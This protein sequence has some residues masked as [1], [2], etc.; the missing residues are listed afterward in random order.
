MIPSMKKSLIAVL[1]FAVAQLPAQAPVPN[2]VVTAGTVTATA[3]TSVDVPI[4]IRDTSGTPLGIDQPSGSRIQSYSL[5]VNYSP[6]ASVS[7][8]TLSR[9]GITQPLTP[10]FESSPSGPGTITLL[11][12]F[13][14]A[15]NLIPFTSNSPLPGNQVAA[16]HITVSSAAAGGS[17]ITLTFD[18]VL[19]QLTDQAGNPATRETTAAVNL[20][21]VNGAVNVLAAPVTTVPATSPT[22]LAVLAGSLG[23]GGLWL[24]GRT[25]S[26]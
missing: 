13:Q 14:E 26:A 9:A 6:A 11:D 17:T 22:A 15:T 2:D 10:S 23:I 5:K 25:R 1:L 20:S 19:T 12:T 8:I 3:G 4:Y 18:P 21:L 16:L 7:A 24:L